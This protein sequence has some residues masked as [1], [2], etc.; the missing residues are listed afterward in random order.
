M[1]ATPQGTLV[2]KV[3]RSNLVAYLNQKPIFKWCV[4]RCGFKKEHQKDTSFKEIRLH[5]QKLFIFLGS[6]VDIIEGPI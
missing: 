1:S 6:V 5:A 2:S 4:L 3:S